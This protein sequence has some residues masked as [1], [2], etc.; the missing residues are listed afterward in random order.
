MNFQESLDYLYGLGY[1]LSV[2][3]FGLENT[4]RL[5]GA[6]GDPQKNFLKIQVAGTNGKGSTCAFLESICLAA[7]IR[8]GLNTS[9]HLVSITERIRIGGREIT[10]KRFAEYVT[11]VRQ[12]SER[13]VASGG[14]AGMPTFF[15]HVTVIAQLFFA[16]ERAAAAILEVGLG[17]RF[18]AT[19]ATRP[20]I[21]AITPID[22]DHTNILGRT[23]REI[24]A[25]KAAIIRPGMRLLSAPQTKEAEL[26]IR[27]KCLEAGIEPLWAE[28]D[29]GIF[30]DPG[31]SIVSKD[32]VGR[33]IPVMRLKTPAD[34]YR[35]ELGQ[36][37][38]KH[39]WTNAALAVRLAETV[40]DFGFDI[41]KADIER[42]VAA[43]RFPGRLEYAHGMLFDGA[44][45]AAGARALRDYLETA[46]EDRPI[47]MIY[48]SMSEKD[49]GEISGILFPLAEHLILTTPAN[50]RALPAR[51]IDRFVPE[52]LK[53]DR[54]FIIDEVPRAVA[55]AREI[56]GAKNLIL[57]TGS[58]YLIGEVQAFLQN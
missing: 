3:K 2:K 42:G 28:P 24:A 27:R 22:L 52:R 20:E 37:F 8:V 49:L 48:G 15:E 21:G 41:S 51:E 32:P 40:R 11:R 36:M 19:T 7:G 14:L 13:L 54:L 18:D 50:P 55:K 16:D 17:G 9:P 44:H 5:L 58:L 30:E 47:T 43:T 12:V 53:K 34:V 45:N 23:I 56:A 35:I 57:V 33:A 39:Q 38:G 10:E 25:E 26:V 46:A 4:L 1:E 31:D 6:L 29:I